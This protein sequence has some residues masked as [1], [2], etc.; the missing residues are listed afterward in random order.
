V[1]I[2][3]SA[4][5]LNTAANGIRGAGTE[6]FIFLRLF[7]TEPSDIKLSFLFNYVNFIPL[8]FIPLFS[9]MLGFDAVNRERT[10]GTLSR[11]MSQ[12]VY[13]DSVIN[14][15][16]LASLFVLTLIL[17][18]SIIFIAGYGI[19]MIG[20]PPTS[21]EIIRIFIY[22]VSMIIYGAFWISLSLLFS[23]VFRNLASSIICS[24]AIWLIFS[25]GIYA[26][27]LNVA[28]NDATYQMILDFSP[29]WLFGNAA[30]AIFFPVAR[31][32]GTLTEEQ[33]A[34]MIA[35]PLTLSQS[36]QMI[37]PYMVGL[38]SLSAVCFGI[39]YV[40]FMKQEIRSA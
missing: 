13:R 39:S 33:T 25:F 12:P 22:L 9:I 23:V 31:S 28:N 18:T 15:K 29:N 40:V 37:W 16:F 38:I 8:V 19:R 34:Y 4:L 20:I 27:A 32:L 5:A 6:G 36:L 2:G 10:S 26:L 21:E 3:L 14:G 35:N 7:T 30:A 11:I 24:L 1:M 17:A